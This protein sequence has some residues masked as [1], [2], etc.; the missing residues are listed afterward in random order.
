MHS[1]V[2]P[3]STHRPIEM[4]RTMHFDWNVHSC[5]GSG[6]APTILSESFRVLWFRVARIHL[7]W[8]GMKWIFSENIS[9][10]ASKLKILPLSTRPERDFT[11]KNWRV[12]IGETRPGNAFSGISEFSERQL[13]LLTVQTCDRDN[14]L[15]PHVLPFAVK[16]VLCNVALLS[17]IELAT[18]L[19]K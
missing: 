18:N 12:K 6:S 13:L 14:V 4:F 16:N 5:V 2:R 8:S 11:R 17:W 9:A 15:L 3:E 10:T 1:A 19:S 7:V